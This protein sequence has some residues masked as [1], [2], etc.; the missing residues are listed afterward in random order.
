MDLQVKNWQSIQGEEIEKTMS[1]NGGATLFSQ[2]N[3]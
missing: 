3:I 1:E 2:W